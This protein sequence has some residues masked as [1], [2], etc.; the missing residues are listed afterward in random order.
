MPMG[1]TRAS[2]DAP[3]P[4][5]ATRR[6]EGGGHVHVAPTSDRSEVIKGFYNGALFVFIP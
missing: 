4:R 1:F 6:P 5:C 3:L 2:A